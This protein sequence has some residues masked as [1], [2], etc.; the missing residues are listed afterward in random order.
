MEYQAFEGIPFGSII[1]QLIGF[2]T[3]GFFIYFSFVVFKALKR[4]NRK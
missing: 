1:L 3:L 2:V 4:M